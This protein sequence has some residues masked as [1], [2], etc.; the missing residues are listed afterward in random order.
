MSKRDYY[1]VLGVEKGAASEDIK[2][3][4]RRKASEFHPDRHP[5][6]DES[7]RKE[8]EERFKEVGEAYSV[9]SDGSKRERYDRFG[10][11]AG[12]QGGFDPGAFQGDM[13]DVFGDLFEGFFGGGGRRRGGADLKAEVALD[14]A[15]AVFGK[16]I[17]LDIPALRAC[18]TCGGTGAKEGTR[19]SICK[20]C[21]GAGR[22]RVNQGFFSVAAPCPACHGQGRTNEHPCAACRGE[23]RTRQTRSI[24][25]TVPPGVEDSMQMRVRGEGEGGGPGE[26]DG[27]LY[28]ILRVRS[29]DFFERDG[30]DLICELPVTFTQAALGA[31]VDV[32]LLEG[33]TVSVKVPAGSQPGRVVRVRGKGVPAL[34]GGERGDLRAHLTV[35]VP[36]KL[37][38]RQ[39]E[40]LEAFAKESG[41]APAARKK[42]FVE[43]ARRFF[44]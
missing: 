8:M 31:E 40:L 25:V 20:R 6:L 12:G 23:G 33:G 35:E 43:K 42:G 28:V 37:T 22:V 30:E 34:R 4:F 41:D 19:P 10:H 17:S 1:E 27:D 9:L 11:A 7:A 21:G 38:A 18:Q 15:D 13:G 36:S 32:P 26:S 24:K 29:H 16:E 14:F 5:H 44:E 2:K 3:A 39:R